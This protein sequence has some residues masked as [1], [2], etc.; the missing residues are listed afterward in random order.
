MTAN[1]SATRD[2]FTDEALGLLDWKSSQIL[3]TACNRTD[4]MLADYPNGLY[5][6]WFTGLKPATKYTF[7]WPWVA[8]VGQDEIIETLDQK[9]AEPVL[10]YMHEMEV[11]NKY[12]TQEYLAPLYDFLEN[13]YVKVA[14]GTYM[15]PRLASECGSQP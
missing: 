3:E 5:S 15:S 13:N 10:V 7:L 1:I 2:S 8:K 14:D 12:S 11:W 4:V 9:Q 6:Y